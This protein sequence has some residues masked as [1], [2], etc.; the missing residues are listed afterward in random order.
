MKATRPL[1]L[2]LLGFVLIFL[3]ACEPPKEYDFII[4]NAM[5]YDGSGEPGYTGDLAVNGDSIVAVGKFHAVGKTE[6][7]AEG[8][9]LAP[10]FI[11]MLSWA[12]EALL[13]DGRSL[14]DIRQ[15]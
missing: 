8:K 4:R 2:I 5:I 7:D 1:H 10:G 9:A 14:S 11:N 6:W 15:G 13:R 3:S 12:P